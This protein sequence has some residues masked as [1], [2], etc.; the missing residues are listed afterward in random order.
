M[1]KFSLNYD[2]LWELIRN[3]EMVEKEIYLNRSIYLSIYR[4]IYQQR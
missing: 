4:S 2:T 3:S 1:G